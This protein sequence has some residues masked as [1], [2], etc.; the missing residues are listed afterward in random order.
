MHLI[1]NWRLVFCFYDDY[2]V[3]YALLYKT[4]LCPTVCSHQLIYLCFY[5]VLCYLHYDLMCVCIYTCFTCMTSC[6][7]SNK[8][9]LIWVF[10]GFPGGSVVKKKKKK[11]LPAN[12]GDVGSI[13]GLG[14]PPGE[15]NGNPLQYSCLENPMDRETCQATVPGVAKNWTRLSTHAHQ[16][17]TV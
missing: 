1:G 11:K 7:T 14:R 12:A 15:G 10:M 17:V 6:W 9:F 2:F 3:K 5:F 8:S 4:K 16:Y 13:P